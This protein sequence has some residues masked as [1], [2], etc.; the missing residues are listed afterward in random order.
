MIT[1]SY[2]LRQKYKSEEI[3]MCD[4]DTPLPKYSET[5]VNPSDAFSSCLKNWSCCPAFSEHTVRFSRI[6]PISI[7]TLVVASPSLSLSHTSK[8]SLDFKYSAVARGT[9]WTLALVFTEAA[10]V[11]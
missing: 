1:L 8:R 11:E 7:A 9:H 10:L 4:K 2:Y 6:T 5:T 3:R